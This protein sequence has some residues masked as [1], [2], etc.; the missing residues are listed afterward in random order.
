MI[1]KEFELREVPLKQYLLFDLDGT[2]VNSKEGIVKSV[3]YALDTLGIEESEPEKLIR[4]IGPPLDYSFRTFY[5]LNETGVRRAMEKY[6]ERYSAKGLFECEIYGGMKEL[7]EK[8]RAEGKFLCVATSKP[9]IFT[10]QILD[11]FQI[12]PY[13]QV[14]VGASLDDSLQEKAD[15]IA[16]VLKQLPETAEK[17]EMLMIGDREHDVI[18][19]RQ[20]GIECAG[21][22]HGFAQPG[23]FEAAGA[24]Y[25]VAGTDELAQLL[26]RLGA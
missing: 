3:Y 19:A 12:R 26:E 11:M 7:L 21:I 15:I 6:R 16:E 2:L 25:I 8:L 20:N 4:F 1:R 9:Q 18:G 13:F 23:E 14:V 22:R 17:S 10:E 5:N 24:D